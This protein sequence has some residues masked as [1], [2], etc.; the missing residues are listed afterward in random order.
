MKSGNCVD[1][2]GVSKLVAVSVL[3]SACNVFYGGEKTLLMF[4]DST[5][6][7]SRNSP[8]N[9]LTELV[10]KNLAET[11]KLEL[12]VIN[13]GQGGNTAKQGYARLEK[14]VIAH[15]PDFVSVS[16][17]LNDTGNSTT[18]EYQ[19]YMEKIIKEIK[20]KTKAEIILVTSTP[21]DNK[22]HTWGAK[23]AAQG[24]LD[25]YMDSKICDVTRKLAHKYNLKLCDLHD[26]FLKQFSKDGKIINTLILPDGV[27]LS[28][29]G[30][31]VAADFLAPAIF[32]MINAR[33]KAKQ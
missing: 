15:N 14:D 27:H 22:R 19:E 6:L 30:N 4:G 20:Q 28:N 17:G 31:K 11:Y 18:D 23:Y 25:E 16:F 5:T 7:C 1:F 13:S 12:K 33:E 2:T 3:I 10:G 24:G 9:K 8:G 26:C 21:F 29:E 32:E